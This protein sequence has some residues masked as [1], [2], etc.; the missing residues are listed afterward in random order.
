MSLNAIFCLVL[1]PAVVSHCTYLITQSGFI[2]S[3]SRREK[4]TRSQS[5]VGAAHWTGAN[6][7]GQY[8]GS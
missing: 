7:V 2:D 6:S 8:E 4:T 1:L 5:R 3:L